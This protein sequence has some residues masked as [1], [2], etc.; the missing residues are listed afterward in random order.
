MAKIFPN[1]TN[2]N[3]FTRIRLS[4]L[5][6]DYSNNS[7]CQIKKKRKSRYHC[8]LYAAFLAQR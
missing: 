5:L 4:L 2:L 1:R 7:S 6:L 8:K 3:S